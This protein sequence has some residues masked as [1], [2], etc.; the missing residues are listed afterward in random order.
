MLIRVDKSYEPII[1]WV[2]G[3]SIEINLSGRAVL[4]R[5]DFTRHFCAK[6]VLSKIRG[7]CYC[8][9]LG[10]NQ[11]TLASV[12]EIAIVAYPIRA[13]VRHVESRFYEVGHIANP[14]FGSFQIIFRT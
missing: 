6:K 8:L 3:E 1:S 12:P 10:E 4:R 11:A 9:G 13:W 5:A 14:I 2:G 7:M